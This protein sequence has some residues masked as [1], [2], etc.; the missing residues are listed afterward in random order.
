MSVPVGQ[1]EVVAAASTRPDTIAEFIPLARAYVTEIAT[2]TPEER[3]RFVA[4]IMAA[5]AQP[6]YRLLLLRCDGRAIGFSLS[7]SDPGREPT[8]SVLEFYVSPAWRRAGWGRMLYHWTEHDMKGRGMRYIGLK[9]QQEA[10]PF[11]RTI[12]FR[13]TGKV[14]PATGQKIL[15]KII[16]SA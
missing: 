10:E 1:V 8:G 9:A 3:G 16:R 6:R 15:A 14:D 7:R 5:L 4:G 2:W 11:W 12:G 13:E